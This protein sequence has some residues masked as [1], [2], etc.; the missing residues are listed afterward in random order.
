MSAHRTSSFSTAALLVAMLCPATTVLAQNS[1]QQLVPRNTQIVVIVPGLDDMQAGFETLQQAIPMLPLDEAIEGIDTMA[2]QFGPSYDGSR[3]IV[4]VVPNVM[5]LMT[6]AQAGQPAVVLL[7]PVNNYTAFV[8]NLGGSASDAITEIFPPDG[9][10][11]FA[12]REGDY[13]AV[14][15]NQVSLQQYK[16]GGNNTP[17][18]NQLSDDL[19]AK[20][21]GSALAIYVN[22]EALSPVVLP[23]LDMGIAQ[24]VNQMEM[25]LSMTDMDDAA[26]DQQIAGFKMV[27]ESVKTMFRDCTAALI[28]VDLNDTAADIDVAFQMKPGSTMS[29]HFP[30]GG[31]L[32]GTIGKLP[33]E[34]FMV[35]GGFDAKAIRLSDLMEA[36]VTTAP[37]MK[38]SMPGYDQWGPL[39]DDMKRYSYALYEP[40]DSGTD[41]MLR[42]VGRIEYGNPA[43]AR[44]AM[45]DIMAAMNQFQAPVGPNGDMMTYNTSTQKNAGQVDGQSY[46][47]YTYRL[48]MPPQVTQQMG[49]VAG[50]ISMVSNYSGM[51]TNTENTLI[52]T[53]VQDEALLAA[54]IKAD[55][56]NA[57]DPAMVADARSSALPE[58]LAAE[59]YFNIDGI[60]SAASG[61]LSAMGMPEIT[62][63]GDLPPI[64]IGLGIKDNAMIHRVHLPFESISFLAEEGQKLMGG[65]MGAGMQPQTAPQTGPR[66]PF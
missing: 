28:A 65:M 48:D 43:A 59:M 4:A 7:V 16:P 20:T 55:R 60:V 45:P 9:S 40:K 56:G 17:V 6:T 58:G 11:M 44:N 19:E 38:N 37:A 1:T 13:A 5:M 61:A 2:D 24:G 36:M 63:P 66:A 49:P 18:T 32:T 27:G 14:S 29:K 31:N 50:L 15:Q 8:E 30:G 39:M 41:G 33:D 52:A 42:S 47:T 3:A 53:T 23:F 21:D 51:V 57:S 22:L 12:K 35:A 64:A 54:A 25:Q 62:A 26:I 34:P 10:A 46:D